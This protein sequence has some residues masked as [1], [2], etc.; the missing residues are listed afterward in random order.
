MAIFSPCLL[1]GFEKNVT[2][3]THY[4]KEVLQSSFLNI[5]RCIITLLCEAFEKFLRGCIDSC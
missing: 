1:F 2:T 4:L 5:A 3:T